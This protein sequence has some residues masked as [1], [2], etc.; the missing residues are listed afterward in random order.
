MALMSEIG[1]R[2]L[3]QALQ[4]PSQRQRSVEDEHDDVDKEYRPPGPNE[5]ELN[6]L[7]EEDDEDEYTHMAPGR[8]RQ[9][10]AGTQESVPDRTSSQH[11]IVAGQPDLSSPP[12]TDSSVA[13]SSRRVRGRVVG[14]ESEKRI[15]ILGSRI[16]VPLGVASRAFEGEYASTFAIELGSHIRKLV[17][18]NK[19]T[20]AA[21]DDGC[22]EAI[23]TAAAQKY[24]FGD[25]KTDA[26]VAIAV[27][28]LAMHTYREFRAELHKA[29]KRLLEKGHDPKQYPY[30]TQR[31]AQ[32]VW[33]IENKWETPEWK[34][35]RIV[36]GALCQLF[37]SHYNHLDKKY[38]RIM[39]IAKLY[40]FY[41]FFKGRFDDSNSESFRKLLKGEGVE[42][43]MFQIDPKCIDWEDYFITIHLPGV[44][45]YLI[46]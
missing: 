13:S 4:N 42:E 28:K 43:N 32:W 22:K 14:H 35:F 26:R 8:R 17:P 1:A 18:L 33:L 34:V 11:E 25:R 27:G 39:Q 36:S 16:S 15:R 5:E 12:T 19:E 38:K 20:W 24:D 7:D 41:V 21:I 9:C 40:E 2:Q 3:V 45:K 6:S 10:T 37:N 29:Y 30:N 44:V 46:K 23:F 31:A